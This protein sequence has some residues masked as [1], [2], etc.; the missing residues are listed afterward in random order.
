GQRAAELR[1]L[2]LALQKRRR[3]DCH[4]SSPLLG[5]AEPSYPV[6]LSPSRE[7]TALVTAPADGWAAGPPGLVAAVASA[8][9]QTAWAMRCSGRRVKPSTR[10][11]SAASRSANVR[12]LC[13]SSMASGM[14]AAWGERADDQLQAPERRRPADR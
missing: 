2:T 8:R 11:A 12:T 5:T 14:A 10:T 1:K 7:A 13:G 6:S 9:S 3:L 4:S